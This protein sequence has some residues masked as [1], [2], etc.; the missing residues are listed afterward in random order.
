[1][2]QIELHPGSAATSK[3]SAARALPQAT[4]RFGK[5]VN[6]TVLKPGDL[7]LSRELNPDRISTHITT[8]QVE[9]GYEEIDGRWTHA[10]MYV[11][12][13][14]N[15]VEATFDGL[16][17]GGSV[18]LTSLDTYC[19]GAHALR[20]RRSKFV[21]DDRDGWRVCIRALSRLK[22]PYSFVHLVEMWFNVVF[23]GKGFYSD[24]RYGHA[25]DAIVCSTLYADAYNEALRRSLGEVN[26][27]CVPAWLSASDEFEDLDVP[28]TRLA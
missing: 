20:F 1:V 4:R 19:E 10:A 9:G 6:S 18:R 26:G 14:S 23:R 8:V 5:L 24:E 17:S 13:D 11:G 22:E 21:K 27:L 15:V 28:W 16:T 2:R 3:A 25:A 7:L 12:D